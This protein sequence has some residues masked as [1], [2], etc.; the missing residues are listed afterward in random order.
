MPL[1]GV[2]IRRE[3]EDQFATT[4]RW[5]DCTNEITGTDGNYN[6]VYS[7]IY[8]EHTP[9]VAL[10]LRFRNVGDASDFEKAILKLTSTPI[11]SWPSNISPT[12]FVHTVSD[13]GENARNYRA[14]LL[15]RTRS[16]WRFSALFYVYRDTD[17]QYTRANEQFQLQFHQAYYTHYVSNH[18]GHTF[19]PKERP[20]FER[21]EKRLCSE[22]SDRLDGRPIKFN[23]EVDCMR[24]LSAISITHKIIFSRQARSLST[25]LPNRFRIG[26]ITSNKVPADVQLWQRGTSVRLLTRYVRGVEDKWISTTVPQEGMDRQG[27]SHRAILPKVNYQR[28]RKVNISNMEATDPSNRSNGNK[29]GPI[30]I[31]FENAN[32]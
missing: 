24:F 3:Q 31:G 27:G 5:S 13:T 9:N 21:C 17:F 8:R 25:K 20:H 15:I 22:K 29:I 30:V 6:K 32:G 1:S 28:G 16:G 18:F 2:Q 10:S 23:N 26:T 4:V 19:L 12:H 14:I 11:F 7:Y